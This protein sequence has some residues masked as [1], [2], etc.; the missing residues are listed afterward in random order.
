MVIEYR[1]SG[2]TTW[3]QYP[4]STSDTQATVQLQTG[5]TYDVRVTVTN[6]VG[7]SD[8]TQSRPVD[9][10]GLSL[11]TCNWYPP[12]HCYEIES[13]ISRSCLCFNYY[14]SA[15]ENSTTLFFLNTIEKA[16][17]NMSALRKGNKSLYILF[18]NFCSRTNSGI[19]SASTWNTRYSRINLCTHYATDYNAVEK[20][21]CY[22]QV[23]L[24]GHFSVSVLGFFGNV[25]LCQEG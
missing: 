14:T 2:S 16:H 25:S 22:R 15:D 12:Y 21:R 20:S 19:N 24:S 13:N 23:F 11:T 18:L 6:K 4:V 8:T 9:V 1:L 10:E 3:T 7:V 5:G 17:A